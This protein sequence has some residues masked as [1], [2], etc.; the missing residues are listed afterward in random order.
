MVYSIY[1]HFKTS[2]WVSG[3]KYLMRDCI[4]LQTLVEQR[5]WLSLCVFNSLATDSR[6]PFPNTKYDSAP[7]HKQGSITLWCGRISPDLNCIQHLRWKG[8]LT[9]T[10]PY[11]PTSLKA[12]VCFIQS[13]CRLDW[14]LKLPLLQNWGKGCVNFST[15]L[16]L[17]SMLYFCILHTTT[18]VTFRVC[19]QVQHHEYFG[20]ESDPRF[21]SLSPFVQFTAFQPSMTANVLHNLW[22]NTVSFKHGS[23]TRHSFE[24]FRGL[25]V[26]VAD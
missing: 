22:V 11:C 21:V 10:R 3:Q 13:A 6:R 26:L 16:N 8:T 7:M 18:S 23:T 20:K 5:L 1:I 17:T 25:N 12:S 24:D 9:W 2:P 19:N 4:D 14:V 15:F